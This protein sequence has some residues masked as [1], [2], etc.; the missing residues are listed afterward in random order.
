MMKKVIRLTENDLV[1]IVKRVID[2]NRELGRSLSSQIKQEF[3]EIYRALPIEVN[4]FHDRDYVTLS[5][6]FAIEHA[7]NNHVYHEEP[8]HVIKTSVS[9]KNIFNASNPGEY[10]YSGPDKRG[11]EIYVSKGPYEY[12]GY[13]EELTENDYRGSHTSPNKDGDPMHDLDNTFGDDVYGRNCVRYFGHGGGADDVYSCTVIGMA[14]GKPDRK[15][16]I[17]RAVPK[18]VDVINPGDWVTISPRYA[19][20]HG[21]AYLD[22]YDVISMIVTT[23]ELYNDGN[24]IHEWG[25]NPE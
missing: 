20:E 21:S 3:V 1:R 15:I 25:Y 24:S 12:E 13:D 23:K 18:G 8:Y 10:F 17:Y 14:K 11:R 9:T 22:E 7:E 16:K 19:K 5:K 2:E 4:S 6:K